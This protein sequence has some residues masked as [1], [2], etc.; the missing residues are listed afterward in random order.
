MSTEKSVMALKKINYCWTRICNSCGQFKVAGK[1]IHNNLFWLY[2]KLF[3][4]EVT[5]RGKYLKYFFDGRSPIS[6]VL[7]S[8]TQTMSISKNFGR[9]KI[10]ARSIVTIKYF[11]KHIFRDF[12][13]FIFWLCTIGYWTAINLSWEIATVKNSA[14]IS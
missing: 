9:W 3:A 13:L 7:F 8:F 4:I 11:S 14:Q 10:I 12:A 5:K 1:C 6:S 2:L